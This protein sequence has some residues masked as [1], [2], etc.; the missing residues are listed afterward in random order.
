MHNNLPRHSNLK[1]EHQKWLGQFIESLGQTNKALN[2]IHNYYFDLVLFLEWYEQ[3][4]QA[5]IVKIQTTHINAYMQ[6]LLGQEDWKTPAR[7]TRNIFLAKILHA[8]RRTRLTPAAPSIQKRPHK[9]SVA[10]RRRHL[11][12]IKNFFEFLKEQH[13][14][15][16][17]NIFKI[18]PV[19]SKSHQIKLTDKDQTP[20]S[21][22]SVSAW[23]QVCESIKR[24]KERLLVHLLY[25]GGLR[26][27]EVRLLKIEDLNQDTRTL[28]FIRKG[29][30]RHYLKLMHLEI[31]G[32][33]W[34]KVASER[35]PQDYLFLSTHGKPFSHRGLFQ[36]MR[37]ILN[38]AELPPH[39]S[40]HSFRKACATQLYHRTKDLLLVRDYLNHSDA[41]VTQTYIDS[42]A[43][44]I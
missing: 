2:T 9:L 35:P 26:L 44:P 14:D 25:R 31:I 12:S 37:N 3:T 34:K 11:S 29:G 19:K 16:D 13:E 4:T 30:K 21:L 15:L 38:K 41:K 8:I 10:A 23:E 1:R 43:S 7:P 24:P 22:L 5:L 32:P 36:H 33:L 39:I 18:N 40:P 20:T 42:G 6:Y 17:R 28:T 27:D